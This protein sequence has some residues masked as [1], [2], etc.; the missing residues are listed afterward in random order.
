MRGRPW[1]ILDRTGGP[2]D[3]V[4]DQIREHV[5]GLLIERL[6]VKHPAD[7]DNMYFLFFA[8][9]DKFENIQVETAQGGQPP[10][11]IEN[12][13]RHETTD[14]TE[15]VTLIRASLKRN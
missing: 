6:E 10:F 14:P 8:D 15:A 9:W 5:P 13:G 4:F 2:V 12:D 3:D 7:D 11:L 1:T